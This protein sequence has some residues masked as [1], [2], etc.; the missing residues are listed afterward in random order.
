MVD[1]TTI[2]L[3]KGIHYETIITT[4]CGGK[5]N[6][7][8]IGIICLNK[9][10][11][12]CRIFN[13][14][15]T[16]KN[17]KKTNRFIVN[18]TDNPYAFTYSTLSTVSKNYL[19]ED[20]SLKCSNSYFKC[21]VKS[22][23]DVVKDVDPI[24]KSKKSIIKAK[25]IEICKNKEGKPINR[26]MDLIVESIYNIRKINENPEYYLKRLKEAKR[27]ITKVG[28]IEDKKSIKIIIEFL[29]NKGYDL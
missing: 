16:L 24:N 11:V 13:T 19:R 28:S 22:I 2:G 5:S 9:D 3:K 7:A 4:E 25:V 17:I 12:M 8:P 29:K 15:Q 1:L 14:S 21:E 6:S 27:V 18:I 23:K 26:S 20:N 10:T